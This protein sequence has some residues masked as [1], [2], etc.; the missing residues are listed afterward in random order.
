MSQEPSGFS[1]LSDTAE[2]FFIFDVFAMGSIGFATAFYIFLILKGES[3]KTQANI[4]SNLSN[5]YYGYAIKCAMISVTCSIIIFLI[6]IFFINNLLIPWNFEADNHFASVID[7]IYA[8]FMAI[9]KS[10]FYFG[11]TFNLASLMFIKTNK[12]M[13]TFI[14]MLMICMILAVVILCIVW[15]ITDAS[16]Y[17]KKEIGITETFG[18][19]ISMFVG[20]QGANLVIIVIFLIIVDSVYFII[21]LYRYTA[22]LRRDMR[23]DDKDNGV[24]G[25]ILITISSIVW[26]INVT[27]IALDLDSKYL[28]TSFQI[29]VDDVCLFL[30]FKNSQVLYDSLCGCLFNK[31]CSKIIYGGKY[32]PVAQNMDVDEDYH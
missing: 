29:I 21:L 30:M 18:F 22:L 10:F 17:S 5:M 19:H 1:E 16:S 27:M 2:R 3:S 20:H 26:Y 12:S 31:C 4:V 24:K 8:S 9:G 15:I 32:Q 11:F 14:K 13:S 28:F 7:S 23:D 25:V 6:K